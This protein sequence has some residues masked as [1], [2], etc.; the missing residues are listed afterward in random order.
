MGQ[1]LGAWRVHEGCTEGVW[2]VCGE[3]AEG[4]R[5]IAMY[6]E[7]PIGWLLDVQRVCRVC[8]EG[9][10]RVCGVV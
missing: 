4:F 5:M 8:M 6:M 9:A 1:L 10:W 2:K 7:G 3:H